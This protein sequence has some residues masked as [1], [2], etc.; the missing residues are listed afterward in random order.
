LNYTGKIEYGKA[1][2]KGYG[3]YDQVQLRINSSKILE[4][5]GRVFNMG[6]RKS[7][8]LKPP[9][10]SNLL[11]KKAFIIGFIDGDGCIS[12]TF[13]NNKHHLRVGLVGTKDVLLWIKSIFDK[14]YPPKE[15]VSN[16]LPHEGCWRYAVQGIRAIEILTD[17][18]KVPIYKLDR[19][20]KIINKFG[21]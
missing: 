12:T 3:I 2:I 18:N 14:C 10:L 4:D 8:T 20:W 21:V 11:F 17:L 19:K 5:L 9:N 6:Q 1:S 7:F 15:R 13:S 16:V